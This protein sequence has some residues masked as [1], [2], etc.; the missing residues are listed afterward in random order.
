MNPHSGCP[1]SPK[2]THILLQ[3]ISRNGFTGIL[4]DA[5]WSETQQLPDRCREKSK[6]NSEHPRQRREQAKRKGEVGER[7]R[8]GGMPWREGSGLAK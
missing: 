1:F 5:P 7:G 2:G 6:G 4:N 8:G 3:T